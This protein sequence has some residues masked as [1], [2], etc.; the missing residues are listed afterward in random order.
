MNSSQLDQRK[1]LAGVLAGKIPF[2][3]L[4]DP[5]KKNSTSTS[6]KP[7]R[8]HCR[9]VC[10]IEKED[11]YEVLRLAGSYEMENENDKYVAMVL[12][13]CAC[14]LIKKQEIETMEK[15]AKR[16]KRRTLPKQ[17][18]K[19][20]FAHFYENNGQCT[21][22]FKEKIVREYRVSSVQV[23]SYFEKK[24]KRDEMKMKKEE[25]KMKMNGKTQ[26]TTNVHNF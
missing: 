9:M 5:V 14:E 18:L 20:C 25:K 17:A 4:V 11:Y 23:A 10:A 8:M 1:M 19:A 6:D 26:K 2:S 15:K 13:E 16:Q 12:V 24:T 22:E 3:V 7:F 21:D